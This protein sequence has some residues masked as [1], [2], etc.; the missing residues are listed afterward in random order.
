MMMSTT[1]PPTTVVTMLRL[2][3]HREYYWTRDAYAPAAWPLLLVV[4]PICTLVNHF[5]VESWLMA[6]VAPFVLSVS[7]TVARVWLWKRR[8]PRLS[9]EELLRRRRDAATWN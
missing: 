7:M 9:V 5:L 4:V 3:T 1:R 6:A 2:L 8:H